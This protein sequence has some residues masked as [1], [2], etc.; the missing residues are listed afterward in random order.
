MMADSWFTA[1]WPRVGLA[2]FE[3]DYNAEPGR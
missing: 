2:D 3:G 1:V